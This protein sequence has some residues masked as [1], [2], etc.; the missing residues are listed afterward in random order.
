ML[1][2]LAYLFI[3]SRLLPYYIDGIVAGQDI[4]ILLIRHSTLNDIFYL[5]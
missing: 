4:M 1:K 5:S 3:T 2:G